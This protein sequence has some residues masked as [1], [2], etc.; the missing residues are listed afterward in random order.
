MEVR[1]T[2]EKIYFMVVIVEY[3]RGK[4]WR[5]K[6]FYGLAEKLDIL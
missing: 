3:G 6:H 2:T 1:I 4:R 5:K